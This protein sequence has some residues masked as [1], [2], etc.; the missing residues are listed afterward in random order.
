LRWNLFI[1]GLC[2]SDLHTARNDWGWSYYTIVPGHE[3]VG[4]VIAVV[5]DV[6]RYKVRAL[7][8]AEKLLD[9]ASC[10][11]LIIKPFVRAMTFRRY[12]RGLATPANGSNTRTSAL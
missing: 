2:H 3:I 9:Q 8:L 5:T 1:A 11:V 6:L 7:E 10:L 12:C 4:R